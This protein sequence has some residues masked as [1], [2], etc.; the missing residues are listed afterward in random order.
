MEPAWTLTGGAALA[1]FHLKHRS[2][3][4]LDLFW[5]G[6]RDLGSI[7][8]EV[9]ARLAGDGL[10]VRVLQTSPTFCRI[11]AGQGNESC[12]VDLVADPASPIEAPRRLPLGP[13]DIAVDTAHEILVSK[14][15][16]LLSRAELRDLIDVRALLE[17][18]GD[19]LG[20]LADAPRKDGGFS[21]LTLAWVLKT[22]DV[23]PM[24]SAL[25]RGREEIDALERFKDS[26]IQ[27]LLAAG[28]P[29]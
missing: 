19:L 27:R 13:A 26:L 8:K 1:G 23:A 22:A 25:G 28:A 3:R 9:E 5:R 15:C 20:A 6:R 12:I 24:S 2:T 4:D 16:A 10:T 18:G 14:L 7:P 17:A 29:E 11:Q 21:P